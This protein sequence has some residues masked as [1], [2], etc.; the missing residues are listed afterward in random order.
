MPIL[1]LSEDLKQ[2]DKKVSTSNNGY[3][4]F[5]SLLDD[6]VVTHQKPVAKKR[7][8]VEN[9]FQTSSK[10]PK[11]D[12]EPEFLIIEDF[13]E[14]KKPFKC[15]V[16]GNKITKNII[17]NHHKEKNHEETKIFHK[18]ISCNARFPEKWM[19]K[20]HF[21]RVHEIARRSFKCEFC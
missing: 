4:Y 2:G 16:L 19:L 21:S 18:C 1:Q 5:R 7:K 17:L 3:Q 14:E 9:E 11:V 15:E 10:K 20:S 13:S 8:L 12:F 6:I